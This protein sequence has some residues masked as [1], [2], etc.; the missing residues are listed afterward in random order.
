MDCELHSF[1]IVAMQENLWSSGTIMSCGSFTVDIG[2]VGTKVFN[3][4]NAGTSKSGCCRFPLRFG[5]SIDS[6]RQ[7]EGRSTAASFLSFDDLTA[8]EPWTVSLCLFLTTIHYVSRD[9]V[10]ES[11]SLLIRFILTIWQPI[12][13]RGADNP[14]VE[15]CFFSMILSSYRM[16][17][18]KRSKRLTITHC[19]SSCF[20]VDRSLI[21][22]YLTC[23]SQL[24][25]V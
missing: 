23:L 6:S 17:V 13:A 3:F 15:P 2:P 25:D 8:I 22:D 7:R 5:S 10:S 4:E 11:K 9:R 1:L 24:L 20:R 18:S 16:R 19:L 12:S 14:I 21:V